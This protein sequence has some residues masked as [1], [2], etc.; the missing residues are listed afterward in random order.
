[1]YVHYS[2]FDGGSDGNDGLTIPLRNSGN[3]AMYQ[4]KTIYSEINKRV[5]LHSNDK[6]FFV[7]PGAAYDF[8]H[9]FPRIERDSVNSI[10]AAFQF[11][12]SVGLQIYQVIKIDLAAAITETQ[13]IYKYNTC[14]F[15]SEREY[16]EFDWTFSNK[17]RERCFYEERCSIC[18]LFHR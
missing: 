14:L 6:V 15:Y 2:D 17:L 18:S 10:L 7:E 12:N 13:K 5:D 4:C 3:D 16:K 8:F 11:K 1:M 9:K